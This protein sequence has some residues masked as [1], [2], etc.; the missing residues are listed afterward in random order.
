M[1]RYYDD[2]IIEDIELRLDIV[3]VIS[4]TVN[5]TRKGNRYWGI[6]PFH[7]EK[8]PSFSVSAERKCFI[9]LAVTQGAICFPL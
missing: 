6:C 7:A 2:R 4:E 5:L 8:T 9:V 3:D 1:T